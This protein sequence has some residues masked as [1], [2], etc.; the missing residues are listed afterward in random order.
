M[1]F[2]IIIPSRYGSVRLPGKPLIDIE[3][4]PLVQRVYEQAILCGATSVTIATD[5]RRIQDCALQ[6]GAVVCM[7]SADHLTGTD[8][9]AEAATR[10]GLP[11]DAIVVNFQGD[12]PLL[13]EAAIRAVTQAAMLQRDACAATVCVPIV[14]VEDLHDPSVA[15]VVFDQ[16]GFALYF[17]RSL[18]PFDRE[19]HL[20]AC[21][22]DGKGCFRHVGLYAYRVHVLK[23]FLQWAPAPLEL[24]ESL[25][26]LRII[27]H[28]EK[29]HVSV[30]ETLISPEVNT[31]A[32]LGKV[33]SIFRERALLGI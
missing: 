2:H 6:F 22:S 32:D 1:E 25:E 8:R 31:E 16:L 26:Q 18:I 30:L 17:S 23:K 3:G 20:N 7:T 29:I 33:R 13:P 11:D 5:D 24:K 27:W 19:A 28:G 15:K 9:V 21:P 10:L 12:E 4:K 14:S